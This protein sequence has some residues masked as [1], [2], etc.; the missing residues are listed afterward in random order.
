MLGEPQDEAEMTALA[1]ST[2]REAR[3]YL[4]TVTELASGNV[5]ESALAV[6]MLALSQIT[7]V[8][9][10]LGAVQDVVPDERYEPDLG[11]DTDVE[12]LHMGLANLLEGLDEYADLVDPLISA[13]VTQG[14][15]S[16]DLTEIAAALSHG[17]R[18]YEQGRVT[19]ALWW[20]QFS[21]MSAWGDRAVSGLRMLVSML[22]HIRLDVDVE[23]AA[24]A[25]FEALYR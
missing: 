10:R 5:E 20:W 23:V 21:F 12:A 18:H 15:L 11:P 19:E 16:N 8:G 7:A 4:D 9:A 22:G 3:A 25:E 13:D 24:E 2:A 1:D 14:S 6:L 17:L